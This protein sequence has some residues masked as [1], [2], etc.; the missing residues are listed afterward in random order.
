MASSTWT[1]RRGAP[2]PFDLSRVYPD[3]NPRC[4]VAEGEVEAGHHRQPRIDGPRY[5]HAY[6][7]G[8]GKMNLGQPAFFDEAM[9]YLPPVSGM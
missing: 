7:D 3:D 8:Q 2:Q 4:A 6:Q 1:P 5:N 9:E